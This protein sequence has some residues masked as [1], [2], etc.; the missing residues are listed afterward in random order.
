MVRTFIIVNHE[1]TLGNDQ[2][3]DWGNNK[4][5]NQGL[6]ALQLPSSKQ[7][8]PDVSDIFLAKQVQQQ[9]QMVQ[10]PYL[11]NMLLEF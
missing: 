1:Y 11:E 9:S 4:P 7:D 2:Y 3:F 6:A 10:H 5:E 8:V